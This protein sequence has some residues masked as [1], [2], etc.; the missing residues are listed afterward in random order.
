MLRS[1]LSSDITE[2]VDVGY[3]EGSTVVSI[4]NPKNWKKYGMTWN[5]E[6]VILWCDGLKEMKQASSKKWKRDDSD[7]SDSEDDIQPK[8]SKRS[9]IS[10]DREKRVEEA[11]QTLQEKQYHIIMGRDVRWWLQYKSHRPFF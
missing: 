3:Y 5:R 4:R 7:D 9:A 11:V 8:S 6:K 2:N 10:K 1:Q